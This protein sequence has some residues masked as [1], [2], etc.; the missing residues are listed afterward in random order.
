MTSTTAGV[1]TVYPQ[2]NRSQW[3]FGYSARQMDGYLLTVRSAVE[4]LRN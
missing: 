3:S 4:Q 2:A 1:V